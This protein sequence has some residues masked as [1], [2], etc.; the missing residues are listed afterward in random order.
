MPPCLR[1]YALCPEKSKMNNSEVT[2]NHC[3]AK[4]SAL[5]SYLDCLVDWHRSQLLSEDHQS[6]WKAFDCTR[7]HRDLTESAKK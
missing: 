4:V 2:K 1:Y 6:L 3:E 7:L 5:L